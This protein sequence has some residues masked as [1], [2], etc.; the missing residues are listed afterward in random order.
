[1]IALLVRFLEQGDGKL[2]KRAKEKEFEKLTIEEV[3]DIEGLYKDVF[4][5]LIRS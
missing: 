1:M 4:Q 2:S 3:K 5:P